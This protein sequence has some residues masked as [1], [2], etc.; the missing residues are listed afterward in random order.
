MTRVFISDLDCGEGGVPSLGTPFSALTS[1]AYGVTTT[2]SQVVAVN[3]SRRYLRITNLSTNPVY[4]NCTSGTATLGRH[5]KIGN[6]AAT[7]NFFEIDS[8]KRYTGAIKG[9]AASSG[10]RVSILQG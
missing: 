3:T 1:T 5:I 4:L 9:I 6:S 10:Q 2:S 8:S 7:N